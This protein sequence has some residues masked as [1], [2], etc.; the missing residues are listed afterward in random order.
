MIDTRVSQMYIVRSFINTGCFTWCERGRSVTAV[1][2]R[3]CWRSRWTTLRVYAQLHFKP[4][5]TV[6]TCYV[7]V[8]TI[9][10][11]NLLRICNALILA[12]I[13]INISVLAIGYKFCSQLHRKIFSKFQMEMCT[14][15]AYSENWLRWV[16]VTKRMT[17]YF[18]ILYCRTLVIVRADWKEVS[19]FK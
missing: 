5:L 7:Y 4:P 16:I 18:K 14:Y 2:D 11:Y 10:N 6:R 3:R 8:L 12:S 13:S 17:N 19:H 1:W 9:I 15:T